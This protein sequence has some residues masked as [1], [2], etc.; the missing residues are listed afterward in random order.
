MRSVLLFVVLIA[1]P[2][3]TL[4]DPMDC[5]LPGASVHGISQARILEWVAVSFSRGSSRPRD[6]TCISFIGKWILY[7]WATKWDPWP[8]GS[9]FHAFVSVSWT[10]VW[11]IPSAHLSS[12]KY[13]VTAS[14]VRRY[15]SLVL[16]SAC[17]KVFNNKNYQNSC[18]SLLKTTA[19]V[20]PKENR[21]SIDISLVCTTLIPR[22]LPSSVNYRA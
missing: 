13:A 12:S 21:T 6:R 17:R 14:S 7:R 19:S 8:W 5:S 11:W 16:C 4:C 3:P 20:F 15:H 22:F 1:Q 18:L 10:D 2:C 9:T